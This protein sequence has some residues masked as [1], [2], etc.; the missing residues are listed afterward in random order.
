MNEYN[1]MFN[2]DPAECKGNLELKINNTT[3]LM[4]THPMFVDLTLDPKLTYST[5]IHILVQAHKPIQMIKALTA[6]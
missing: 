1:T 4:A 3:L 6:T 5:H 2:P